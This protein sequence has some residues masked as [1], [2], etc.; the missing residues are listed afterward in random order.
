M[1]RSLVS[2][3]SLFEKRIPNLWCVCDL[4]T[5]D[6]GRILCNSR[7]LAVCEV[8]LTTLAAE[9]LD[10]SLTLKCHEEHQ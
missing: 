8:A 2:S 10:A 4:C 5:K 9:E 1:A 3:A 6:R 7:P